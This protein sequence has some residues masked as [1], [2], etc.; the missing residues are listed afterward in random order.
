MHKRFISIFKKR[1]QRL[2]ALGYDSYEIYLQSSH[3]TARRAA[4]SATHPPK[5]H[6]CAQT[7]EALHHVSYDHLGAEKDED[8]C[9]LCREHHDEIH[10]W[11]EITPA[12]AA[13]QDRLRKYGFTDE[14]LGR[15]TRGVAYRLI[16]DIFNGRKR[17]PDSLTQN[18]AEDGIQQKIRG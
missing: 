15:I 5:C 3:W 12:T 9:W 14:V 13:Q 16:D 6:F 1:K 17:T 11:G 8:L 18:D 4:Y 7:P 2:A 10:Q